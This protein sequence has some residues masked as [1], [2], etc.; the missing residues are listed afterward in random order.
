MFLY[1][2]LKEKYRVQE[3]LAEAGHYDVRTMLQEAA[4]TTKRIAERRNVTIHYIEN[5]VLP[6]NKGN[7]F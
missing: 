2:M 7:Q 6:F 5:Q 4:K 1:D 3:K